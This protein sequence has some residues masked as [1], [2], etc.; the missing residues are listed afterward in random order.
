MTEDPYVL[1]R[2]PD[3]WLEDDDSADKAI[4]AFDPLAP[5]GLRSLL[6]DDDPIIRGRALYVF[7]ELGRKAFV[8]LDA[9]LK[10]V[11]DTSIYSRNGLMDGVICYCKQLN[12]RQAHIVLKL[13][14]DPEVLIRHKVVVFL[15]AAVK[16]TID[17]AIELFEEPLRSEYRKAFAKFS[18][19]PSQAQTLFEEGLAET[20]IASTFA[21]AAI[22]R[23]A[24]DGRL[25]TVPQYSGDSYIGECVVRNTE[26]L[27][28][29]AARRRRG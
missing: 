18:A 26:R 5:E 17:S 6:L 24:R 2:D 19:E 15:G 10:S 23:M 29:N 1:M 11:H 13:A 8:V 12:P 27:M 4:A 9:A 3:W 7:G 16:D 14:V 28:E 22:E 21:F 20:S 25:V